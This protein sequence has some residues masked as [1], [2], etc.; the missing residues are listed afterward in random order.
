MIH[1]I[2]PKQTDCQVR[3]SHNGFTA[4]LTNLDQT[5]EIALP[6]GRVERTLDNIF[7]HAASG[8]SLPKIAAHFTDHTNAEPQC[9]CCKLEGRILSGQG[10]H[11]M[12][13]E[14]LFRA[15]RAHT[16]GKVEIR[17]IRPGL[18]GAQIADLDRRASQRKPT[19]EPI[20]FVST[21][22]EELI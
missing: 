2:I 15:A 11:T 12:R 3:L 19:P 7:L 22:I 20:K 18:S 1:P 10:R 4:T 9:P 5:V 13:S 21:P 16:G 6:T 17:H 8:I 14:D